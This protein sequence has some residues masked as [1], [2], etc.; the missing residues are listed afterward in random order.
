VATAA[1][2][3]SM[4]TT[5]SINGES[6]AAE[7]RCMRST[8]PNRL[9]RS[10]GYRSC[11]RP[12]RSNPACA[13]TRSRNSRPIAVGADGDGLDFCFGIT[14]LQGLTPMMQGRRG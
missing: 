10:H 5:R 7:S 4:R 9:E 11:L 13:A 3:C 8:L 1:I 2:W 6:C 14:S 12:F